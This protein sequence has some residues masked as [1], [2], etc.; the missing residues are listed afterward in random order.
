MEATLDVTQTAGT[1]AAEVASEMQY[2]AEALRRRIDLYCQHLHVGVRG[3]LA[4]AY[5]RQISDDE[6]RLAALTGRVH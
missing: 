5:L 6:D 2:A 1:G 4:I 3:T